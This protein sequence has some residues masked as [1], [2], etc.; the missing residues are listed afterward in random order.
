MTRVS[1]IRGADSTPGPD[2]T[3]IYKMRLSE[4]IYLVGGGPVTGFGLTP[5]SDSHVYL[6]DAG[7]RLLLVDAG[8][9]TSDGFEGLTANISAHG[10]DPE[11]VEVVALTHY[12]GDHAGG[13][14]TARSELGSA[15]AIGA[16]AA[17]ALESGDEEATGMRAAREAGIFG[18]DDVMSSC[19]VDM[20]LEDD[21]VIPAGEGIL[22]YVATPGHCSGHGAYL[23]SGLG[24][25]PALF[26]GDSVFWAGRILLQAVP[27][28]DLQDS[29]ESIRRLDRLE[30]EAFLPGHGAIAMSGGKA[31]VAMAIT[32]I[33]SLGVPKS[34][35]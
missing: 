19:V 31:H 5:G 12:H 33:E 1:P 32:E 29:I 25:P 35:L 7:G 4:H 18:E 13:A 27:D 10:F 2:M 20:R 11:D 16:S 24:E 6:I 30:F 9:G 23:L 14:A 21:E 17:D 28:C 3:N 26:S 34:L 22:R 8:L 15:I